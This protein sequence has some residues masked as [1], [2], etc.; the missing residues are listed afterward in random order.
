ME[1]PR[2]TTSVFLGSW[3]AFAAVASAQSPLATPLPRVP[4]T[5]LSV[6]PPPIAAEPTLAPQ[7][8]AEHPRDASS[9]IERASV[10]P[11]SIVSIPADDERFARVHWDTD[12]HGATWVRG[13]H[14]KAR[15][16]AD[17]ATYYPLF[18]SRQPRHCPLAMSLLSATS[19]G[20]SI[21]LAPASA[22]VRD[23]EDVVIDR[24]VIDEVY[25]V[26]L[27]GLE[28]TFVVGQ[29]PQG[30][31]TLFV[32][33]DTELTRIE[34][35]EGLEF[36]H[37]Q[38]GIRYG[39]AF[40]REPDGMRHAL[41]TRIVEGGVEIEV[42]AAYLATARYPLVVDPFVSTF[43]VDN[44]SFDNR[45][46]EIAYD[47]T[48]NRYLV[49][50]W[51]IATATDTDVYFRLLDATGT[52]LNGAYVDMT[53]EDWNAPD[54][55][56]L[57]AYDQFLVASSVQSGGVRGRLIDAPSGALLTP[58]WIAPTTTLASSLSCGGDPYATAPAYYCVA[59]IVSGNIQVRLVTNT[60]G[61]VG[62]TP[63]LLNPTPSTDLVSLDVSKGNGATRWNLVWQRG[64][65]LTGAD[66]HGAQV[67]WDGSVITTPSFAIAATPADEFLPTV[68]SPL[69]NGTY[70]VAWSRD[71]GPHR[72]VLAA[73]V[74]GGTVLSNAS[75]TEL[76][77]A[78]NLFLD[79]IRPQI[80]SDG[81]Q[82]ALLY[83]EGTAANEVRMSSFHV[84]ENTL[85]LSES[86]VL[87]SS[88]SGPHSPGSL[89]STASTG[90]AARRYAGAWGR[91]AGTGNRDVHAVLYDGLQGGPIT[92][93]CAGDGSGTAC[94]CANNGGADRGCANSANAAGARLLA[95]GNADLSGDTLVLNASGMPPTGSCLFFQGTT[96]V[97]GG[98][99]AA[100]GDGLRCAGGTVVRLATKSVVGGSAS[101]PTGAEADVSVR[102]AVPA[103]GGMRTYQCWYRNAAAFCTSATFNLT[104]GVRVVWLP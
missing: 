35:P 46:P 103:A 40:A 23:G 97:T 11:G 52:I 48:T 93:Y 7:D 74:S 104:N 81:A 47:A 58:F 73:L 82:I 95:T 28:Q 17:G 59:W 91:S 30:N 34:T 61:L 84:L 14:Y 55:A 100:F 38:G 66:I 70:V 16:D 94:P 51:E 15:F 10:R 53:T 9:P 92:A 78:G 44:S 96:M 13:R 19:G 2:R 31:L 65:T 76:E 26:G 27:D 3:L 42:E 49:A 29:R 20:Q 8:R 25:E 101:Y 99:G 60:G 1:T 21:P 41:A 69:S 50:Y 75:L 4:R 33:L 86:H 6:S 72:D 32:R 62:T 45:D 24:G 85:R 68:S 83:A 18:G 64:Y 37:E 22:A 98:A 63:L 89:I 90:G 88:L 57:N 77:N 79:Q 54:V 56:N 5:P 39:H 102:G 43:V 71:F 80:D 36:A 87:I 12:E 67:E